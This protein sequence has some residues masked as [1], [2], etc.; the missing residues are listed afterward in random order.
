MD[1]IYDGRSVVQQDLEKTIVEWLKQELHADD[2]ESNV[3]LPLPQHPEVSIRP[4]FYSES[5]K[6]IGEIHT[7]LGQLKSAQ[8]HKVA[9]DI[10]KLHLF[11]PEQKYQKY[12]VVCSSAE[13]DLL[14]GKSYLAA[15]VK[16]FGIK[17]MKYE[18]DDAERAALEDAMRKQNMFREKK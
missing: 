10:M 2:L 14:H 18:P 17:P 15:A 6:I 7:H 8:R 9:A 5:H 13:W 11:D 4:D 1:E 3:S 16:Q 12:Y